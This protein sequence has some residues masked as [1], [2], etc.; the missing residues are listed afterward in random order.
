[1]EDIIPV[2]QEEF[3]HA[4]LDVVRKVAPATF[5]Y[6]ASG[7]RRAAVLAGVSTKGYEFADW[8]QS[9]LFRC[10]DLIFQHGV[11]HLVMPMLGPSQ[12]K[13]KTSEYSEYLWEWFKNGLT[14]TEA[15]KHYKRLGWR[16]RIACSEFI[17]QVTAAGEKL[18]SETPTDSPHTLWCYVVPNFEL[19][20]NWMIE[21]I[22][23]WKPR[24]H[25]DAIRALYGENIPAA[26]LYMST[27]KPLM[28]CLQL[29]PLLVKGV[30][31]CYWN[32]RPGYSLDERQLRLMFYDYA[33]LRKTWK[34][35]K[36]GRAQQALNHRD[37][38]ENGSILGLGTRLG[39]FWYPQ[40]IVDPLDDD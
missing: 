31:Q 27:G 33:Y 13:E 7:T 10:V 32:Q 4:S 5:I 35:D 20:Y 26:S 29:P 12:F 16:V 34:K 30:L 22:Q 11:E 6:A 40:S 2:T 18:K 37:M 28:S 19:P 17:P 39:P 23:N 14:G 24:T 8:T 15:I 38:W 9:Q 1:M 3:L 21:A 36:T 25:E